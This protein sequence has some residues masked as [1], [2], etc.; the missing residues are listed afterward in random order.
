VFLSGFSPVFF[1]CSLSFQELPHYPCADVQTDCFCVRL[2]A[3]TERSAM[4][5]CEVSELKDQLT[6]RDRVVIELNEELDCLRQQMTQLNTSY[7][8][9]LQQCQLA[10]Q[11]L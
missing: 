5:V 9:A 2:S 4:L 6:S 8:T 10:Q 3:E 1:I 7:Q 11:A